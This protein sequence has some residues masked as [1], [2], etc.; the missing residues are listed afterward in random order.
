M[1]AIPALIV[2]LGDAD[3][4]VRV[5]AANYLARLKYSDPQMLIV[6]M[7]YI[8]N[9]NNKAK[10]YRTGIPANRARAFKCLS[11]LKSKQAIPL[12]EEAFQYEDE[13]GK[14]DLAKIILQLKG[15]GE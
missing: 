7:D 8:K 12:L 2:A 3:E 13:L 1:S 9:T 14:R 4:D 10:E 15:A 5:R 11:F 6:A